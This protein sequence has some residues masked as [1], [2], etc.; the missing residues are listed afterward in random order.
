MKKVAI[1]GAGPAGMMAA[2]TAADHGAEVA[3]FD[4][5]EEVGRKLALAGG[6]RCNITHL[7]SA[8][9]LASHYHEAERFLLSSLVRFDGNRLREF[10]RLRLGLA[11]V[12]ES[13]GRVFPEIQSGAQ[14]AERFRSILVEAGVKL[15]LGRRIH[16]LTPVADGLA[17]DD[18]LFD[19]VVLG[20][21]GASYPATGSDGWGFSAAS[22]LGHQITPL[23]PGLSGLQVDEA[24]PKQ[25]SGVRL[26]QAELKLVSKSIRPNPCTA[27]ELLFTHFGL[28]GPAALNLSRWVAKS[29]DNNRRAD[30]LLDLIPQLNHEQLTARLVSQID[31]SPKSQIKTIIK[32]LVPETLAAAVCIQTKID[33][34]RPAGSVKRTDLIN[35][36]DFLKRAPLTITKL[37]PLTAAKVTVGGVQ[38]REVNPKTMASKLIRGLYFAGEI[39][40]IDG[41]SGGY[42][43]QAAFSTG[44]TAGTNAALD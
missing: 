27:G 18:E 7:G 14:V 26:D 5:N 33:P 1:I 28:S 42:N 4:T 6:T 15:M 16:T 11:T 43:L 23:L 37:R 20:T 31:H 17:V 24:W 44:F 32:T 39:L 22:A 10:F 12:S 40:D 19:A 36:A 21:G 25:L 29:I 2:L 35:L 13:D 9:E 38:L 3:L 41:Q 34:A 8:K 30:L